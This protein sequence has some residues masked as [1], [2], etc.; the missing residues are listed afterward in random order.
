M[1]ETLKALDPEIEEILEKIARSSGGRFL[2][3]DDDR[4]GT[5]L[6]GYELPS[7][8]P[9]SDLAAAERHLLAVH[10]AE[11]AYLL[12]TAYWVA[13]VSDETS[14]NHVKH[15]FGIE[16]REDWREDAEAE[17]EALPLLGECDPLTRCLSLK[18]GRHP[19]RADYLLAALSLE[20]TIDAQN[21]LALE[22]ILSGEYGQ[23]EAVLRRLETAAFTP[24]QELIAW[25]NMGFLRASQGQDAP[26]AEAFAVATTIL[27]GDPETFFNLLRC[28]L[29]LGDESLARRTGEALEDQVDLNDENLA[30]F[31]SAPLSSNEMPT[32]QA[33]ACANQL[34]R[35]FGPVSRR[36]AGV[37]L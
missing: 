28:A 23:A 26:A 15:D 37:Y 27:G 1:K 21:D 20:R 14:E 35:D 9:A 29:R 30:R 32:R 34:E 22:Y 8:P 36:I 24:R 18:L 4:D 12:R 6:I 11:L 7:R 3:D 25:H 16:E 13:L 33:H 2:T 5:G 10:R 17:L 19:A 31:V